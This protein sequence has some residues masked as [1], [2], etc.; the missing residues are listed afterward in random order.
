LAES[1]IASYFSRLKEKSNM[2]L[3]I[4]YDPGKNGVDFLLQSSDES[5]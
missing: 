1:L 3:G 2:P 4:F 5:I